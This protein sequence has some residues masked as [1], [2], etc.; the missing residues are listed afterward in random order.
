MQRGASRV[1]SELL[2]W[3]QTGKKWEKAGKKLKRNWKEGGESCKSPATSRAD[4][5]G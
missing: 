4:Q 3:A 1:V 5:T 2:G